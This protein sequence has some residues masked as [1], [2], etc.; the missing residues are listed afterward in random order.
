M[1]FITEMFRNDLKLSIKLSD[2]MKSP[3][4]ARGLYFIRVIGKGLGL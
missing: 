2:R 1:M 3:V 4:N